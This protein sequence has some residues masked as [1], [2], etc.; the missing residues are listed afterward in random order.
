MAE[1]LVTGAKELQARV[2]L[3]RSDGWKSLGTGQGR[4]ISIRSA[5]I[6]GIVRP[7]GI[8]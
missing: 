5:R 1:S 6:E 3:G 7:E 8:R 2:E 4:E